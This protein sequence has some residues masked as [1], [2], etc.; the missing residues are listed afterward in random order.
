MEP[1]RKFTPAWNPIHS[2]ASTFSNHAPFSLR[3]CNDDAHKAFTENFSWQGIHSEHQ[4]FLSHFADSDLPT[5]IHSREW[6]SLCDEPVTCPFVLIQEFY[7]NMHRIDHSVPHFVTQAWGISIPVTPQLIVDVLRVPRIEF[8]DYPS[9]ERLSTVSKDE[10]MSTFYECPSDWVERQFTYCLAFAKGPWFLNMV[11]TFVLY[12]LSYYNSITES[13][14]RFLLSL[15]EHLTIDFPSHFIMSLI[16]VFEDSASR[17]KLFFPS[18]I[19]RILHHFSV[20]FLASDPFTFMC[21]IDAAIVK[22]SEA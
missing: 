5:V 15:L 22:L 1:K 14:T 11:I 17:D 3:F 13:H 16:N 21:A 4:V 6:E 8:P 9:Y 20:P 12:P 2:G 18:A 19:K 7:S 10:L